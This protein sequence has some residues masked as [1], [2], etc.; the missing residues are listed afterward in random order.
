MI[1]TTAAVGGQRN[2]LRL[3]PSLPPLILRGKTFYAFPTL[4]KGESKEDLSR[5]TL[6][7]ISAFL[8]DDHHLLRVCRISRC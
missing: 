8:F 6:F 7:R 1:K 2:F 5:D 3:Y 4:K